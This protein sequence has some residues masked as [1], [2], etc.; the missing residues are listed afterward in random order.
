MATN[1]LEESNL[2]IIFFLFENN[3]IRLTPVTGINVKIDGWDFS[4]L[5]KKNGIANQYK[6]Y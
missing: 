4:S 6:A 2:I 3:I 5:K 1:N